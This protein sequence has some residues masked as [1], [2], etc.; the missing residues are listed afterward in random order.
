VAGEVLEDFAK[1]LIASGQIDKAFG[2]DTAIQPEGQ[3]G[4]QSD[5]G[6]SFSQ[7]TVL[8]QKGG[9]RGEELMAAALS[10]QSQRRWFLADEKGLRENG[11][12][13]ETIPKMLGTQG[14][15]QDVA[16][17]SRSSL[18]LLHWRLRIL[19]LNFGPWVPCQGRR[20]GWSVRET[21][22]ERKNKGFDSE[23]IFR[24]DTF[25]SALLPTVSAGW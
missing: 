5:R 13:K 21:Q 2:I 16:C 12:D 14:A 3:V 24:E 22:A 6:K 7:W 23:F 9:G 15:P 4:L 18:K 20:G 10:L 25:S 17:F 1:R 8:L 19:E 11:E